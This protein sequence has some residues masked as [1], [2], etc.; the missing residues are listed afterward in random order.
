MRRSDGDRHDDPERYVPRLP[1]TPARG[2]DIPHA[3]APREARG[4]TPFPPT[5]PFPR[6]LFTLESSAA[7]S[8]AP[9]RACYAS[10]PTWFR[11]SAAAG[12]RRLPTSPGVTAVERR[13]RRAVRRPAPWPV[14]IFGPCAALPEGPPYPRKAKNR[15]AQRPLGPI[16]GP[17]AAQWSPVHKLRPSA[18]GEGRRRA[19][20]AIRSL[21]GQRRAG[22][23]VGER[24][25]EGESP[26]CGGAA[27]GAPHRPKFERTR[28]GF[29]S[30]PLFFKSTFS[31]RPAGGRP[32]APWPSPFRPKSP[33][34]GG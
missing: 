30:S 20:W 17:V 21:S 12:R 18:H 13:W 34:S 3:C 7:T 9:V 19:R 24:P 10:N 26:R 28:S 4:L 14:L 27:S 16:L 22:R 29:F 6:G 15:L 31:T 8:K 1:A 2:Q 11:G 33:S 32:S 25:D 23:R 5:G